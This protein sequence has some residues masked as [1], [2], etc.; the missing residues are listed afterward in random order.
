MHKY[1]VGTLCWQVYSAFHPEDIGKQVTVLS[2]ET[3]H[4]TYPCVRCGTI[5]RD[6]EVTPGRMT[7]CCCSLVPV[8]NPDASIAHEESREEIA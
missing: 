3:P 2:H 1:P 8:N 7:S 6:V 4:S 5:G